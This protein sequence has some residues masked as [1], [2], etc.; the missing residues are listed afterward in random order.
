[1]V[2]EGAEL[3]LDTMVEVVTE[4]DEPVVDKI[5][6]EAVETVTEEVNPGKEDV[7]RRLPRDI[8]DPEM[9]TELVL[10]PETKEPVLGSPPPILRPDRGLAVLKAMTEPFTDV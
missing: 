2:L 10:N 9:L 7:E 5:V 1:M 6:E 8:D 4:G 3:V